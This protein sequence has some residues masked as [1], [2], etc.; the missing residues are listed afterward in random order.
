MVD[1]SNFHVNINDEECE[2]DDDDQDNVHED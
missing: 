1:C 2:G